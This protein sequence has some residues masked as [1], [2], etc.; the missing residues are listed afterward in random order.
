MIGSRGAEDWRRAQFLVASR[1]QAEARWQEG[2]IPKI[3]KIPP[4]AAGSGGGT[5]TCAEP[6][7]ARV[8]RIRIWSVREGPKRLAHARNVQTHA[9]AT[10]STAEQHSL[11]PRCAVRFGGLEPAPTLRLAGRSV[12]RSAQLMDSSSS[13]CVCVCGRACPPSPSVPK[14]QPRAASRFASHR[15]ATID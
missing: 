12:G 1:C 9:R 8:A 2:E 13:M 6:F 5:G 15:I 11:H 10:Q 7:S 14:N 3:P 4:K